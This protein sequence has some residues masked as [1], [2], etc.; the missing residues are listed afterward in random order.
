MKKL[1]IGLAVAA[2]A[3]A[4]QASTVKWTTSANLVGINV[5]TGT[6]LDGNGNYA[7]N[8]SNLKGASSLLATLTIFDKDGT[9]LETI[10]DVTVAYGLTGGKVST[11]FTSDLTFTAST[12]Y[13]YKLLITGTQDS[14]TGK[15]GDW[16]YTA[17]TIETTLSGTFTGKTGSQL[18]STGA[19]STW[20]VA[21]A[22]AVPEP[23]SGLLLLL[24]VAGMALRRR[25]A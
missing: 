4:A 22:V 15:I 20:D 17:A 2:L 11:S 5:G 19:A 6:L 10:D 14:L 16:D 8:G 25:R 3:V 21:G 13:G 12:E 7:A 18:I 9:E 1:M 24:G 23:T